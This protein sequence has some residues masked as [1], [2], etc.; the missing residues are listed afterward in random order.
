MRVKVNAQN[1]PAMIQ[2]TIGYKPA[3]EDLTLG[4]FK[5][6]TLAL[7]ANIRD[8]ALDDASD[9]AQQIGQMI[10]RTEA[11]KIA[12]FGWGPKGADNAMTALGNVAETHNVID[13]EAL[14]I[15]D[16]HVRTMTIGVDEQW[17]KP[18]PLTEPPV[19]AILKTALPHDSRDQFLDTYK[20]LPK[21]AF[22]HLDEK[23]KLTYDELPPSMRGD[24]VTRLLDRLVEEE[25]AKIP[26]IQANLA[27]LIAG[28]KVV[29]DTAIISA[30]NDPIKG[31]ALI[32][33]YR[34]AP[35]EL[36]GPLGVTAAICTFRT[37]GS[38]A[39][40]EAILN[41]ASQAP[42]GLRSGTHLHYL[43]TMVTRQGLN[44]E[45]VLKNIE[46][47]DQTQDFAEAD[48]EWQAARASTK[49]ASRLPGLTDPVNLNHK[50]VNLTPPKPPLPPTSSSRKPTL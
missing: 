27:Y 44:P 36:Q 6:N 35:A 45:P 20:P 11:T 49:V 1:L 29:R 10:E 18:L 43:L 13:H 23:E 3:D 16:G 47:T 50:A 8:F 22:G 31:R 33:L 34:E 25:P 15:H 17:T 39:A 5:D 38:A 46:S 14:H 30:L 19:E 9:L 7:T 2:R 42:H 28:H 32:D 21:P 48:K 37:P 26:H 40:A 24:I 4:F 12:Y 41:Q